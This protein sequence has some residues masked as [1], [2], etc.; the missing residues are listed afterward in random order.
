MPGVAAEVLL[1]LVLIAVNGVLSGSELAVAS[2]RT[3]RLQERADRG[4]AGARAALELAAHPNRFLATV[5]IGITLVGILTGAFGGARVAAP[6]AA[7]L[8]GVPALAPHS[9]ALAFGL[10][11]LAVTYLSL[12]F[13]ELVPKRLALSSPERLA[14]AVARPLLRLSRLA[15]PVVAVLG[16]STDAV[17]RLLG[18]RRRAEAPV[19]EEELRLLL[20]QGAAAGVFEPGEPG[21]VAGV[22]SLADRS[23]GEL[24]TPRLQLVALDLDDPPEVNARTMAASPHTHL[25]VYRGDLDA[26]VGLVSVK[27]V[28]AAALA[29]PAAG[30]GGAGPP[31]PRPPPQ[32][33]RR[34]PPSATWSASPARRSTS[35]RAC[36][37]CACWRCSGGRSAPRAPRGRPR[38]RPGWRS[39]SAST[40]ARRGWSP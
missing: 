30:A 24:M 31:R 22:L 21:L 19:T 13:G 38:G 29:A 7:A 35:R 36:G 40:A 33:P 9:A 12:V 32:T 27:D 6:L 20:R 11:V 14:A 25:P 26:L 39:S 2:A 8:A 28:W 34:W 3:A 37:P 4:D 1:L 10:V 18:V 15:G 17:L 16:A 23:V 5:Q